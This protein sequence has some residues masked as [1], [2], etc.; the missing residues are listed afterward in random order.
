[1][2]FRFLALLLLAALTLAAQNVY[3]FSLDGLGHEIL[4]KDPVRRH[5]RTAQKILAEGVKADGLVAAFPSTTGNSHAALFTGAYGDV[6]QITANNMP[7][8]PRASHTFRERANGFRADQ[9]AAEPLWVSAAR[10]NVRTVAYQVTQA[11]PFGANNT[12][13]GAVVFNSYQTQNHAPHIALRAKDVTFE[14]VAGWDPVMPNGSRV[15]RAFRWTAG[16]TMFYGVIVDDT[17]YVASD[18]KGKKNRL[19][20]KAVAT[21]GEFPLSRPLARHFSPALIIQSPTPAGIHFRLFELAAD[22]SDFLLYHTPIQEMGLMD[23]STPA[24]KLLGDMLNKAGGVV[25]NGAESLLE[26]GAFGGV[27]YDGADDTALRRYLETVELA[28]RQNLRQ[29]E[30]LVKRNKPRLTL[31]YLPFP[32]ETDHKF[33]ALALRNN[34]MAARA[35][36]WV[37]QAVDTWMAGVE[38]LAGKHALLFVSDHGMAPVT[39][40]VSVNAALRR[41]GLDQQAVHIYNSILL[42]TTDWKDGVVRPEDKAAVL[43]RVR[44]TL[45]ALREPNSEKPIITSF[46]DPEKEGAAY[47]IRCSACSDLYLDLAPGW[48]IR[49]SSSGELYPANMRPGGAHGFLPTRPEMLAVCFGRGGKLPRGVSWPRMKSIDVAPLASQLLDIQPP[50]QSQGKSPLY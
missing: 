5:L 14:P 1:M 49:D 27:N 50:K 45:A 18:K 9:L 6:S 23:G 26:S 39:Q 17:M 29:T 21:E 47:G 38:D 20:L 48:V 46:I 11:V 36:E 19:S 24:S 25:S 10:Q 34:K 8:L 22:G 43:N 44:Q 13:P 2:V 35:R 28:I 4:T 32:D 41:A 40:A 15:R 16:K 42:N 7:R 12:H 30:F 37:Y 3:V 31:G 33:L